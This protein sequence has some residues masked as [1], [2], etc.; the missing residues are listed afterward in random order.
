MGRRNGN[1]C[2]PARCR[3]GSLRGEHRCPGR[4]RPLAGSDEEH[5]DRPDHSHGRSWTGRVQ[6]R[7]E[8]RRSSTQALVSTGP[9]LVRDLLDR[10]KRR[11]ERRRPVLR[12]V[13]GHHRLRARADRRPQRRPGCPARRGTTQGCRRTLTDE[14]VRGERGHAR[15]DHRGTA[16]AHPG[17]ATADHPRRHVPNNGQRDRRRSRDYPLDASLNARVHGP[18]HDQRSRGRYPDG[19]GPG[20]GRDAHRPVRRASRTR[21]SGDS[22]HRGHL[23]PERRERVLLH[24]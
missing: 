21:R 20:R 13:R 15:G 22:S 18:R 24:R 5:R 23:Q 10:R 3:L 16:A 11:Y 7:G 17:A 14:A 19:T 9:V 12:Q 8:S 1:A 6:R 2:R 4:N